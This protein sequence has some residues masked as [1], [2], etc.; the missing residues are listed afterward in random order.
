MGFFSGASGAIEE[1]MREKPD[2]KHIDR[3]VDGSYE[4]CRS[5]RYLMMDGTC[6]YGT[7]PYDVSKERIR[8]VSGLQS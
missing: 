2:S 5:C 7:C 1:R 3:G 8:S 4:E 6:F